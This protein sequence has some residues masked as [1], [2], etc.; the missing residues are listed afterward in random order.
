MKIMRHVGATP[1]S[2]KILPLNGRGARTGP[3]NPPPGGGSPHSHSCASS[4]NASPVPSRL[5]LRVQIDEL[6]PTGGEP[7]KGDLLLPAPFL[8]VL[9]AAVCDKGALRDTIGEAI[10]LR[11]TRNG[12]APSREATVS[13][14][15][16]KG[17][18][19]GRPA[20][21]SV[22]L[23]LGAPDPSERDLHGAGR[24]AHCQ[25]VHRRAATARR[26]PA[27][28]RLRRTGHRS[29]KRCGRRRTNER[30]QL[31]GRLANLPPTVST[32]GL[33]DILE[34]LLGPDR[35][36]APGAPRLARR[37]GSPIR[38]LPPGRR[39][40]TRAAG[41]GT[42]PLRPTGL[43]ESAHPRGGARRHRRAH[44]TGRPA[45]CPSRRYSPRHSASATNPGGPLSSKWRRPTR[46]SDWTSTPGGSGR[47]SP[48]RA[49]QAVHCADPCKTPYDGCARKPSRAY[50][51][52]TGP[53]GIALLYD[54]PTSPLPGAD[55]LL[56]TP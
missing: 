34:S 14:P 46:C 39:T 55:E 37:T 31:L 21:P 24:R 23:Q 35:D 10:P 25:L 38:E 18:A 22:D 36:P 40:R 54:D 11:Q 50:P 12:V 56:G 20:S 3:G 27:A 44:P 1:R 41:L 29:R 32:R 28:W 51:R 8:Q 15:S 2:E 45:R 42:K 48:R 47:S 17:E 5:E 7:L 53:K 49:M 6:R 43:R 13:P 9:D 26:R 52:P 16:H 4:K 33:L 30:I 19:Q